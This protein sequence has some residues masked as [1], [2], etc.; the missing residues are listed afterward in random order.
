MSRGPL[1]RAERTSPNVNAM[2]FARA[3]IVSASVVATIVIGAT[4]TWAAQSKS[5]SGGAAVIVASA[6]NDALRGGGSNTT[7]SLMLPSP[8]AS[9]CSG[10]SA[11]DFYFVYSYI[12]SA[13][14][15][16]ASL[17]FNPD[18]GPD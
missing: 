4:A 15:D 6:S 3:L 14:F 8:P 16:P 9:N 13:S 5:K 10:D 7:W 11:H 12:V 2:R 18:S 1:M 17:R